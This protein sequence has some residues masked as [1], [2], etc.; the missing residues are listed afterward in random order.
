MDRESVYIELSL[1]FKA[2]VMGS[3]NFALFGFIAGLSLGWV[4][5]KSTRQAP[6]DPISASE[7]DR[8]QLPLQTQLHQAQIAYYLAVEASQFKGG[9][10]AR[11]AHELRSPLNGLIGAHQ[12]IL[13]DL[14]ENP[15]EEREFIQQAHVSAMKMVQMLDEILAVSKVECGKLQV[16][17]QPVPLVGIFQ[18]VQSLTHLLATDRNLKL[19]VNLPDPTI[20]VRTDARW[21]RQ[22]LVNLVSG[23]IAQ[24]PSGSITL[25]L[26]PDP[27]D[28]QI[29]VETDCPLD[30]WSEPSQLLQAVP[31]N[32]TKAALLS[33]WEQ[34]Q[35][36]SP[37]L[38]L[39]LTQ[40]LLEVLQ[41]RLEVLILPSE[42]STLTRIQC[43]IGKP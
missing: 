20:I 14:C 30:I 39:L 10:L 21:L 26:H 43:T 35:A 16:N 5:W 19:Q 15:E 8:T 17:L 7:L 13:A 42:E 37:G 12:L 18:E 3:L 36:K 29:W 2:K 9:F 25:T 33:Q 11:T 4:L 38:L 23:A 24:M 34:P 31:A 41:G 28:I 40:V 22:G 32:L 1:S 27:T 6:A